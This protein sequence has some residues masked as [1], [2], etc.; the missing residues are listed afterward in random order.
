MRCYGD[1]E[2]WYTR[3]CRSGMLPALE[4]DGEF[5]TESDQILFRLERAFGP[6]GL[7]L[8]E[9]SALRRLE[10]ELFGA[11]CEWLCYP[12]SVHHDE[13]LHAQFEG[14]LGKVCAALE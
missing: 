7:P 13:A 1:K 10:R 11:W 12:D 5:I 8:Q 3:L 4:L 9:I 6:L 2:P 14:V